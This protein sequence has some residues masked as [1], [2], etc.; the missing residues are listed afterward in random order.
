MLAEERLHPTAYAEITQDRD[1]K[2][3]SIEEGVKQIRAHEVE[4]FNERRTHA[5]ERVNTLSI[6]DSS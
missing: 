1:Q 4:P 5:K 6:Q 3:E 2:A